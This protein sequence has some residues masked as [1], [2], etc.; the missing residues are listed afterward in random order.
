MR[1]YGDLENI[2]SALIS[3]HE[4]LL[5]H[6]DA[7]HASMKK[8]DAKAM[9]DAASQAESA[10]LR[11]ATLD[12][13]RRQLVAQL[14]QL[15][16]VEGQPTLARIAE[17]MPAAQAQ[18]KKKLLDLR[19]RLKGLVAQAANRAQMSG[20]LAGSVLGHL[21]TVVRLLAGA[22]EQA[23]IYTKHGTPRV[24]SRIGVMEAVG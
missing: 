23:G 10:R 19:D 8:L 5:R 6:L 22:V 13:R 16:R 15:L 18:S 24:S 9:D 7:Q 1:Q 11:I 14:A 12:S 2:L 17:A 20:K 21:N 3:E 4:R